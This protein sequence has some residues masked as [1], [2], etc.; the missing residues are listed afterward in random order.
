MDWQP[1]RCCVL[2]RGFRL[3]FLFISVL[4]CYCFVS[5]AASRADQDGK[6]LQHVMPSAQEIPPWL[7]ALAVSGNQWRPHRKQYSTT[8][9]SWIVSQTAFSPVSHRQVA[10]T[11][12]KGSEPREKTRI[13]ICLKCMATR[14]HKYECLINMKEELGQIYDVANTNAANTNVY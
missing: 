11:P 8:V 7:R 6:S 5:K 12:R 13:Y 2:A 1:S 9:T 10:L 3:E 4:C 14:T